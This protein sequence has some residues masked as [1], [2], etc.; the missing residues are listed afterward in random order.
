MVAIGID[1][2]T[3]TTCAA[4]W[5]DGS[6]EII[7]NEHGNRTT[8]SYVA[9]TETQALVGESAFH[10]ASLNPRNTVF[11][12]KRLIGRRYDDIGVQ[13]HLR[14]F[15]FKVSNVNGKPII[16]VEYKN[17]VKQFTS[18]EISSFILFRVKEIAESYLGVKISKAVITV[19]AYFNDSQRQATKNAGVI[20]GFQVLRVTNEPTAAALAYGLDKNLQGQNIMV[21]DLGGGTFDVSILSIK[22]GVFEVKATAGNTNLGGED[23]DNRLVAYF[24]EDFRKKYNINI[25]NH[26]SVRRLKCAAERTKKFLTSAS[27]AS[28]LVDSVYDGIDYTGKISR[29]LFEELCSDLFND[30]LKPIQQALTDARLDKSDINKVILV[31]GSTRIPKVQRMLYDL[32]EG[33]VT[34][35]LN[36]DEAVAHGAAIQAAILSGERHEKIQD[37]LLIDVVP[38]SLG[39]ETSR[40][41]MY[42]IVE[43]NTSI[44]CRLTK[45][46][47][48]LDDYQNTMTIEIFEG[49]RSLTKD[50][51]L[52]GVFDLR[53]IP[54]AP[55]GV[56]KV[57]ITFDI[58]A[59][60]ILSVTAEDRSTGHKNGIIIKNENRL[61]QQEIGKMIADAELFREE[62]RENKRKLESRNQLE[63]Y[64]F[65]IKNTVKENKGNLTE[66]DAVFME[67]ESQ[68]A[69]AWLDDNPDCLREEFERKLT[70]LMRRWSVIMKKL[71]DMLKH[72]AKRQRSE[73]YQKEINEHGATTIEEVHEH[74]FEATI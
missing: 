16:S 21:Y 15:P 68:L 28:V 32:F 55:R 50:N 70:E 74:E 19:P 73:T 31:G 46:L 11:A 49:E 71:S 67:K 4:V 13:M 65:N 40:G 34:A 51:N 36:P 8:P 26:K 27:E 22:D 9:F 37:L 2:G 66:E 33:R 53:G 62:D 29:T 58:D 60:G 56:A 38:L 41:V 59:N 35:S 14:H 3:T 30:T 7:P 61:S 18:E 10:Q 24:I 1:L 23:F 44:P 5:R 42:K 48:T 54:P 69:M 25:T 64:I 17:Q 52:L 20:A 57:D 63:T 45:D 39:V 43:R 72:R 47:T 12:T 6:V